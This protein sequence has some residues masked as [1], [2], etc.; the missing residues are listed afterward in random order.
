MVCWSSKPNKRL[1]IEGVVVIIFA[2][3]IYFSYGKI[4]DI[5]IPENQP[6]AANIFPLVV[7]IVFCISYVLL[8]WRDALRKAKYV[9]TGWPFKVGSI[10]TLAGLVL[11]AGTY[12]YPMD[13]E[14]TQEVN[15]ILR[16]ETTG[17]VWVIEAVREDNDWT[18]EVERDTVY[19]A[20]A[21]IIGNRKIFRQF[22]NSQ[23]QNPWHHSD[24]WGS[25]ASY[26]QPILSH[27]RRMLR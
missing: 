13:M 4:Y 20:S 16:S 23:T 3:I 26:S 8:R 14:Q 22:Q 11:I 6:D 7:V 2:I 9:L 12:S 10:T 19:L 1:L 18:V 21:T 17:D 24:V 25:D 5:T 15:M 27:V